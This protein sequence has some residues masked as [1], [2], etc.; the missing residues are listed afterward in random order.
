MITIFLVLDC[1]LLILSSC[2]SG[3]GEYIQGKGLMS[4]I[5]PVLYQGIPNVLVTLNP[6]RDHS[7][8]ELIQYFLKDMSEGNSSLKSINQAKRKLKDQESVQNTILD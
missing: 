4:I 5:H 3:K 2:N 6:V 8:S 1:S 7:S